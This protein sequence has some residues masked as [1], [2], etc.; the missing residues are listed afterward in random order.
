MLRIMA[1]KT[2]PRRT[3]LKGVGAT[4]ALPFLDAMFPAFG[5][6]GQSAPGR[7][8]RFQTFYVPNGMAMEYWS[9]T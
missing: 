4:L 2:L 1:G 8:H 3:L 9:P 6:R 5:L 7:V